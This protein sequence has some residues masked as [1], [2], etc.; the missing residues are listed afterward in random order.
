MIA[1]NLFQV[2]LIFSKIDFDTRT[3]ITIF[4]QTLFSAWMC[5]VSWTYFG[6][7][8]GSRKY[9]WHCEPVSVELAHFPFT[10]VWL[11]GWLFKLPRLSAYP[12]PRL[13][14]LLLQVCRL[15]RHIFLCR[16]V[17]IWRQRSTLKGVTF[18]FCEGRST[19]MCRLCTWSIIA[20]FPG[21]PGGDQSEFFQD[22]L[23]RSPPM[24]TDLLGVA[25]QHLVPS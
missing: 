7:Y 25:K 13:V 3:V 6:F 18:V 9:S 24:S 23:L 22:E 4:I 2:T 12:F 1:Y 19:A 16:Q 15:V 8:P 14:V 20:L 5:Y 11:P 17:H 21:S 10:F